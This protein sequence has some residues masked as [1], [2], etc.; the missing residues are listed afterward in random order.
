MRGGGEKVAGERGGGCAEGKNKRKKIMG[1]LNQ[2][3][4]TNTTGSYTCTT[5]C[6]K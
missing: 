2:C 1:K 3:D 4:V 5:V 6:P